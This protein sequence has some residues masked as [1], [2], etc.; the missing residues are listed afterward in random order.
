MRRATNTI[1]PEGSD[2]DESSDSEQEEPVRKIAKQYVQGR[3]D[4]DEEDSIPLMEM[5]KRL[6]SRREMLKKQM[7]LV[8]KN[9]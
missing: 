1:P 5:A 8:R 7:R 9:L 3:Q 2:S 6:K 4:S